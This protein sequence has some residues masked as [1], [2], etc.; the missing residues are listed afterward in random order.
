MI[1]YRNPPDATTFC[2]AAENPS[3]SKTDFCI[4]D[5]IIQ[6]SEVLVILSDTITTVKKESVE[7]VPIF[8]G[9]KTKLFFK[10]LL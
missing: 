5:S 6:A 9:K 1:H 7:K 4:Y 8:V 2:L 10:R 3:F